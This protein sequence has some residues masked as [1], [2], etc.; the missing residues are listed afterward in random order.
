MPRGK[1]THK[2]IQ[3]WGGVRVRRKG[4]GLEEHKTPGN[5]PEHT[6]VTKTNKCE[7]THAGVVRAA[8][9]LLIRG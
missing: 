9:N 6:E 1:E 2:F 5:R 4:W 8:Y 3:A 7:S